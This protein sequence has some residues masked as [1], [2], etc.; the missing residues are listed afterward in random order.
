M[1]E[2]FSY[3]WT[4]LTETITNLAGGIKD[5]FLNLMYVDP[6]AET[7]VI[8]EFAKFGFALFGLSFG[9]GLVWI[10]V[11]KIKG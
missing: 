6:E 1:A 2:L 11:K 9:I 4:T 10:I 3:L 7:K 5:T 8:S